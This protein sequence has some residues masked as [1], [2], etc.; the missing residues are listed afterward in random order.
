MIRFTRRLR[1]SALPISLGLVFISFAATPSKI[2]WLAY[3]SLPLGFFIGNYMRSLITRVPWIYD[4]RAPILVLRS[5]G[6]PNLKSGEYP[7]TDEAAV[8]SYISRLSRALRDVC[9]VVVIGAESRDAAGAV[10]VLQPEDQAQEAIVQLGSEAWV[11]VLIPSSSGSLTKEFKELA[12]FDDLLGKTVVFMPPMTSQILKSL[13]PDPRTQWN[14][15]RNE[16]ACDGLVLPPYDE[17]GLLFTPTCTL[18]IR[19]SVELNNDVRFWKRL[20]D[21]I[22]GPGVLGQGLWNVLLFGRAFEA[23]DP[24]RVIGGVAARSNFKPGDR[25]EYQ[26]DGIVVRPTK[27]QKSRPTI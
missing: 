5:I 21:L 19:K 15:W 2:R 26:R 22:A 3:L 4:F 18:Q 25:I 14:C 8:G 1:S 12:Q 27:E 17:G 11:I 7:N 9:R 20:P 13:G 23:D 6:S 24:T 16:A 10:L